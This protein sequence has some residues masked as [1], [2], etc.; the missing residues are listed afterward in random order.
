MYVSRLAFYTKPGKTGQVEAQL[1]KLCEIVARSGAEKPRVLHTHLASEDA[2]DLVFE[3]E[4]E[5]LAALEEQIR[6]VTE[7]PE[8]QSWSKRI[9]ELLLK[10]PKREIYLI[11]AQPGK[12]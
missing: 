6:S 8:F 11:V 12:A 5:D 9:S 4:V 7:N 2:P 10:S 3:Q 1:Q